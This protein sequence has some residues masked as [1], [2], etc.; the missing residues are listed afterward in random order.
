MPR[1]V[2]LDGT[3]EDTKLLGTLV[4]WVMCNNLLTRL[5]KYSALQASRDFDVSYAKLKRVITG[6]KSNMEGHTTKG[7]AENWREVRKPRGQAK[8]CKA[9]NPVDTAPGKEE[10]SNIVS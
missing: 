10:E 9:V 4:H 2:K 1:P 3:D 5:H 6:S 7:Y 8:K